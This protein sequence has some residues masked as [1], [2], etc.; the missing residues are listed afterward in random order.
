MCTSTRAGAHASRACT[1]HRNAHSPQMWA[2]CSDLGECRSRR[3]FA[4]AK[5]A[6]SP[7]HLTCLDGS[8]YVHGLC[9]AGEPLFLAS[10]TPWGGGL[11]IA[12]FLRDQASRQ[13]SR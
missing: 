12:C 11:S 13:R 5:A 1:A 10:I 8:P 4:S 2:T 7:L 6:R 3:T 9:E